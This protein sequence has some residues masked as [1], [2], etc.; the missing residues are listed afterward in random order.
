MLRADVAGEFRGNAPELGRPRVLA[1]SESMPLLL[2]TVPQVMPYRLATPAA[3][4]MRASHAISNAGVT[5]AP[6]PLQARRLLLALPDLAAVAA[7]REFPSIPPPQPFADSPLRRQAMPCGEPVGKRHPLTPRCA[8]V[9]GT[10]TWESPGGGSIVSLS[11]LPSAVYPVQLAALLILVARSYDANCPE[12][13]PPVA[14]SLYRKHHRS[15]GTH[16]LATVM[17]AHL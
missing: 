14:P 13:H 17:Y 6:L 4:V 8:A 16:G 15:R 1:L 9:Y 11:S 5:G 10:S 7:P 12:Q 3:D 2:P